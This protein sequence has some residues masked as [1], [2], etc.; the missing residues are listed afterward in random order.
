[1]DVVCQVRELNERLEEEKQQQLEQAQR[2]GHSGAGGGGSGSRDGKDDWTE[3]EIQMLIKAVN[4][5]PAGTN[6]RLGRIPSDAWNLTVTEL[7]VFLLWPLLVDQR[8]DGSLP[9]LQ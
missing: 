6:S 4:L 8:H 3:A 9:A 1:M 2:A 5:F 7:R